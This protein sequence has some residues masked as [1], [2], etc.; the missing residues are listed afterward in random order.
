MGADTTGGMNMDANVAITMDGLQE[1]TAELTP[2]QMQGVV[3]AIDTETCLYEWPECE[4][5]GEITI[6]YI[7]GFWEMCHD[8]TFYDCSYEIRLNGVQWN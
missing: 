5:N 7:Y 4:T 3:G 6:C 1:L 8:D 2:E